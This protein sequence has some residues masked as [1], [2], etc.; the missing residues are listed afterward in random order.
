MNLTFA[1]SLSPSPSVTSAAG[2]PDAKTSLIERSMG[3]LGLAD[4]WKSICSLVLGLIRRNFDFITLL[5]SVKADVSEGDQNS[6]NGKDS[7]RAK[8]AYRFIGIVIYVTCVWALRR[9]Q[10]KALLEGTEEHSEEH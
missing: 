5:K 6:A 9:A 3:Q 8:K 7:Y 2:A 4:S 1:Q 10:R